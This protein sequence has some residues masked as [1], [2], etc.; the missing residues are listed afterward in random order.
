MAFTWS[1]VTVPTSSGAN[2]ADFIWDSGHSQLVAVGDSGLVYTT[3]DLITVTKQTAAAANSWRGIAYAPTLAAAGRLVAV[4]STGANRVMY[5]D[6]GGV[7]WTGASASAANSWQAV[8]WAASLTLFVAVASTGAADGSTS[9][10]T[11]PD[12]ITWTTQAGVNPRQAWSGVTWSPSLS[13]LVSASF[14]GTLTSGVIMTS[15]DGI[16]WAAQ[17]TPANVRAGLGVSS[18]SNYVTWDA[19]S[20]LFAA[21]SDNTTDALRYVMTSP[22]GATWTQQTIPDNTSSVGGLIGFPDVGL[23]LFRQ[24]PGDENVDTSA[25]GVTW[26]TE[27]TGVGRLPNVAGKIESLSK[28]VAWCDSSNTIMLVGQGAV[29]SIDS[30]A[31]VFGTK[32]GGTVVTLTGTGLTGVTDVTFGGTAAVSVNVLNDTTL[33]CITPAHAV[34]VVD[35][36]VVGV[37]TLSSAYTFVSVESVTLAAGTVAGGAAVT[38]AG[39]GFAGATSVLFGGVAATSVV[40]VSNL[41]ITAVT[42]AHASGAVDVEVVGV[43]TGTALYTYTLGV[44]QNLGKGFLLPPMPTRTPVVQR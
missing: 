32:R 11:S 6:D 16:A 38:I 2:V 31:P 7:T 5:S 19:A 42:P 40:V 18:G 41:S 12:G 37:G 39:F 36:V 28:V 14:N 17:T 3:P 22:D 10:M 26:T 13:L 25:D 24:N 8:V 29:A 4:S 34:G 23:V 43:D 33:T 9:V 15:T 30:L 27:T 1:E 44:P 21:T 35:V 20:G